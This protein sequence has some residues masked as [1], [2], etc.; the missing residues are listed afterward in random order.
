MG[1]KHIVRP[2]FGF[3]YIGISLF[4]RDRTF[5]DTL[6][7]YRYVSLVDHV[8]SLPLQKLFEWVDNDNNDSNEQKKGERYS[9][10]MGAGRFDGGMANGRQELGTN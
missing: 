10:N 9:R 4:V 1:H 6:I 2:Y 3:I 7:N 8:R 5:S